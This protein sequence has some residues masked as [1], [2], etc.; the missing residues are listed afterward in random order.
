[1]AAMFGCCG[2]FQ[3][4]GMTDRSF[5]DLINE[6]VSLVILEL[7]DIHLKHMSMSHLQI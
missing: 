5:G 1:M 6:I 4:V 7:S 3:E 2:T